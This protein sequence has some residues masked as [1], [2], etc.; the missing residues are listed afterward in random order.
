MIYIDNEDYS[1]LYEGGKNKRKR[2][3]LIKIF[4]ITPCNL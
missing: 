2:L 1:D 3:A 4:C